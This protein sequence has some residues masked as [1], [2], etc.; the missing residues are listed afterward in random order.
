L[1]TICNWAAFFCFF[2]FGIGVT[3]EASRRRSAILLVGWPSAS[4]SQWRVQDRLFE[5]RLTHF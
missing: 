4:S 5:E 1:K 3:Y 2:G